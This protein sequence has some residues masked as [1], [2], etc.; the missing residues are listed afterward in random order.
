TDR[1]ALLAVQELGDPTTE[2]QESG[3]QSLFADD[4]DLSSVKVDKLKM[5]ERTYPQATA[6]IPVSLSFDPDTAAFDYKYTPRAAAGPTEIYVPVALH[7]PQG[8]KVAVTGARVT[9]AAN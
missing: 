4:T 7:Y 9:S 3:A 6:G 8:Y 2:S 5:L 1:L